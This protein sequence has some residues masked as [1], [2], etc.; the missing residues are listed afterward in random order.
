LRTRIEVPSII[1]KAEKQNKKGDKAHGKTLH[2]IKGTKNF[3]QRIERFW[4]KR[5]SPAAGKVKTFLKGE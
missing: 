4:R 1:T 2:Q 5:L 3:N